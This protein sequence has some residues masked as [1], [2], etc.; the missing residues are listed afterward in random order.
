M[1]NNY[2]YIKYKSNTESNFYNKN[3]ELFLKC[4]A[5]ADGPSI[6]NFQQK[7]MCAFLKL[8]LCFLN[9]VFF[10]KFDLLKISRVINSIYLISVVVFMI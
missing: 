7:I 9:F 2:L 3:K 10:R 4:I 8:F 5:Q 6:A 1:F